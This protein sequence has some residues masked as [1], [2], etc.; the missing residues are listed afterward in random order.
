VSRARLPAICKT[1]INRLAEDPALRRRVFLGVTA[2]ATAGTLLVTV[3]LMILALTAR[4]DLADQM[5]ETAVVIAGATLLLA[6]IAAVVALLAYAA[7]TGAPNVDISIRLPLDGHPNDFEFEV[8]PESMRYSIGQ[9]FT[10]VEVFM[11]KASQQLVAMIQ[12]RNRSRY[13]AVNPAVI[14]RLQAMTFTADSLASSNHWVPVE[15]VNRFSI[16]AVQWDGGPWYPIHGDS[17]RRLPDLHLNELRILLEEGLPSFAFEIL[18]DGSGQRSPCLSASIDTA[19][20]T[21]RQQTPVIP[22]G[23]ELDIGPIRSRLQSYRDPAGQVYSYRQISH[24]ESAR[25]RTHLPRGECCASAGLPSCHGSG[26]AVLAFSLVRPPGVAEIGCVLLIAALVGALL[27]SW[28]MNPLR[29]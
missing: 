23:C 16:R 20:R 6:I 5:A 8:E 3:I 2:A 29:S 11:V 14:V 21:Q 4:V 13:S 19:N 24:C 7:V 17:T 27:D 1:H 12:L 18:A 9:V 28:M 22:P 25:E 10:G 26:G 15:F